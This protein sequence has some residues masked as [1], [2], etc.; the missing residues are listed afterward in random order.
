M[1]FNYDLIV[2]GAGA[3]GLTA[4]I[5]ARGFGK[6]VLLIEKEKPGGECTWSGCVPSKGLI[7]IAKEVHCAKKY[8][9]F[10]PDTRKALEGV[11]DVIARVYAHET[12]E[13]L[14]E[15]GINYIQGEARFIDKNTLGVGKNTFKGK[16][17]I[18]ATGSSPFV[19]PIEGLD[20][21]P[22]LTNENLFTLEDLP[23]SMIILGGGAI[24]VEMAQAL[25]RLGVE[26]HLVEMM[27]N[28]LFREDQE[29][30]TILRERLSEEGVNLHIG[31]KAV[32]VED[33]SPKVRLTTEKGGEA[34]VITADSIL[35]AV[36]RKANVEGLNLKEAGID[37]TPKG[38]V[39][40][41]H[42]QTTNTKVYAVGDVVGPYQFSHMANYQGIVAVQNALTPL[43]KS[44]DYTHVTWCTFTE[45]ELA[46]A[47]MDEQ[48]ARREH[49]DIQVY[50]YTA[51]DL[52]RAKTKKDDI[53]EV[54][55][56]C[57]GKKHILGCQ[58]LA[59]R[60]GELISEV[61]AVKVNGLSLDK[62]AGVIHPY[63]SYGEI[64]NK[65][66]KKAY[67]DKLLANPLVHFIQN[68]KK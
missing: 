64:F 60:A 63:P 6:S 14:E 49:G 56:I 9:D 48:T 27:E 20:Q 30:A 28:I 43:R 32:K 22:Y 47:G 10:I 24:G 3:G 66:G 11:R 12:P 33:L 5:S 65:A 53:F 1:D 26:I 2:V 41:K 68:I 44:V 52:D 55:I 16:N 19:P 25:N 67:I 39:V 46:S 21:V 37:Y 54:K 42:L 58:I 62:L 61:Q 40:D 36:G 59:D 45:P 50:R 17:I 7:N 57:D 35:V 34:G 4:S 38:I 29:L 8:A 15:Q 31:T 51:E 23:R 18:I 13:V